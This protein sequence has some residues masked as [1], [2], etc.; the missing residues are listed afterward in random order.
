MAAPAQYDDTF[1]AASLTTCNP[2]TEPTTQACLKAA[3]WALDG[4]NWVVAGAKSGHYCTGLV[5]DCGTTTR[6]M[7]PSPDAEA[8]AKVC[9]G[10]ALGRGHTGPVSC[11]ST[12]DVPT[13]PKGFVGESLCVLGAPN[14]TSSIGEWYSRLTDRMITSANVPPQTG[15]GCYEL[16]PADPAHPDDKSVNMVPYSSCSAAASVWGG[17]AYPGKDGNK[18]FQEGR[19]AMPVPMSVNAGDI[20][21]SAPG[22]LGVACL[23]TPVQFGTPAGSAGVTS[24]C[25]SDSGGRCIGDATIPTV[26]CTGAVPGLGISAAVGPAT[27]PAGIYVWLLQQLVA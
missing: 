16:V 22:G 3:P 27:Y 15:I 7:G 26:P 4:C 10:Y 1:G 19:E 13:A 2:L 21:P 9:R 8:T 24:M 6:A 12:G 14:T 25:L 18:F 11:Q 20:I 17:I 5:G 23:K